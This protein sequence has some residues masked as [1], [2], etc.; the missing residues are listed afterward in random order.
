MAFKWSLVLYIMQFFMFMGEDQW[1]FVGK[2]LHYGDQKKI[3]I[4]P[5]WVFFG[6]RKE[7]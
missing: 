7:K 2:F 3:K 6:K 4:L 1:F 5:Q